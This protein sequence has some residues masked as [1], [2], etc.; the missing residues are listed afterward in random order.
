MGPQIVSR[1]VKVAII[2]EVSNCG[3]EKVLPRRTIDILS[4]EVFYVVG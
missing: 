1:R 3:A 4:C 2:L